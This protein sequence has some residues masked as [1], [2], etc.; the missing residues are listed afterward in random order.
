MTQRWPASERTSGS[1]FTETSPCACSSPSSSFNGGINQTHLP[2]L[3]GVV[4]GLLHY[5]LLVAFAWMFLEGFQ[6]YTV[7]MEPMDGHR[8]WLW[9]F[10][11]LTYIAPAVIVSIA[12]IIVPYSFGTSSYCWL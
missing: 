2:I 12:A 8:S 5:F 11:S 1:G 7:L 9:W 10:C 3:C 6:I 4:A